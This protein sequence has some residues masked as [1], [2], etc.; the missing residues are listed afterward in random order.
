VLTCADVTAAALT[1]LVGRYGARLVEVPAPEPVPESFWGDPEAGLDGNAVYA[2]PDT[3]LHSLLHE[4]GHYVCATPG[5]REALRR[6]A[7]GD[8]DEEAGV[9]FLQIVLADF[10][11]GFGRERCLTDMDAWGYSFR[12]GSARAWLDGDGRDARAWL[13]ER[14]LIDVAERPTWRLRE[15][16]PPNPAT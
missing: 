13:L 9:C 10:V 11:Q 5:R 16:D 2:R 7:G 14:R 6:D 4:L 1:A 12:E 15:A 3:P 8:D